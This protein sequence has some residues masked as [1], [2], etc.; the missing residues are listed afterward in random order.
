MKDC[1][2]CKYAAWERTKNDRLHPN[3]NGKCNF[4]YKIPKLPASMKWC[5]NAPKVAGGFINRHEE[6]QEHCLFYQVK[7]RKNYGMGI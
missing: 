5:V 4:P 6:L 1:T 3:G 7:K 2:K